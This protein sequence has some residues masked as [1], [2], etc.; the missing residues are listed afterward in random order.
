MLWST[1]WQNSL[2]AYCAMQWCHLQNNMQGRGGNL[3]QGH[4]S[5]RDIYCQLRRQV[6]LATILIG[7]A[8]LEA[9]K[10][11]HSVCKE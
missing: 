11:I 1:D 9:P 10:L 7:L 4:L 6:D 3:D 8:S 5:R 2:S